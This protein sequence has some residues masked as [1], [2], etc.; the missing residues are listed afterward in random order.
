M[1]RITICC[2]IA[3]SIAGLF[4]AHTASA[5]QEPAFAGFW[6][7][8][9][10]GGTGGL[11]YD[12]SW[13]GLVSRW[14][15]LGAGNQYLADVEVYEVNGQP[16][17][18]A[19]WRVGRGNGALW[20]SPWPEFAKRWTEWKNT[21]DLIDLEVYENDGKVMY[22]GVFRDKQGTGGDGGL[23]AGLSWQEL[24]AKRKEFAS[25]AYLADVETYM[26]GGTRRYVGVWRPGK[27]NGALYLK[28]DWMKFAEMKESL[29]K[30]QELI[31]FDMFQTGVSQWSFLGVWRDSAAGGPLVASTS[32]TKFV[33]LDAAQLVARWKR[34]QSTH[35]LTGLAVG[36]PTPL[37]MLVGYRVDPTGPLRGNTTCA[38]GDSDCNMCATDVA[39]Q[40]KLAFET[41]HRPWIGWDSRSW[42]F[43]GNDRYPPDDLKP[44]L[45]FSP[46]GEDGQ[47]GIASK[48][49]QTFVR[50]NS[51]RIPYAGSH[52]HRSTGSIFFVERDGG[53]NTLHSIYRS[54]HDHPSGVAVLGDGVFVAEGDDLRRFRVSAAGK[55]QKGDRFTVPKSE[56][57]RSPDPD[58]DGRGLQGGGGGVGLAKL[59]DGSTLLIVTAPGGGFRDGVTKAAREDNDRPR[60]TRV[61][62][63]LPNALA[64]NPQIVFLGE[65]THDGVSGK[66]DSSRAYSENLSAITECGTGH[67]YTIH[68]TGEYALK[69]HGYWRLSRLEGSPDKPRFVHMQTAR[70]SQNNES[71]HH[72][73]SATVSVNEKKELE[74]LCSERAVIKWHPTGRFDFRE[75]TR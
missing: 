45:V 15:E 72:R 18:A 71:C 74:F 9:E 33:P 16:R 41:G 67:I 7:D 26:D 46:Y 12:L 23:L 54:A 5:R 52:S 31:D 36:V 56:V 8:K 73:S 10:P 66:P 27:G 68:T 19:V 3:L 65:W 21:Q 14:K 13:D 50:T 29:D 75:G 37:P 17:Y 43:R 64:D 47:A 53:A 6:S 40:F 61:Y 59:A 44:E 32:S 1:R 62:R 35:T 51:S 22:L 38:Y 24:V 20:A 34:L 42:S 2:L 70:Q 28:N 39:T 25:R 4:I 60:Y 49:I 55:S 63:M 58:D 48:H 57:N 11:F 30:T 69:G